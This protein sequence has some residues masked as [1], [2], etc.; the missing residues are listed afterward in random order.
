[1]LKDSSLVFYRFAPPG[2]KPVVRVVDNYSGNNTLSVIREK[3]HK[4]RILGPMKRLTEVADSV[5]DDGSQR[6]IGSPHGTSAGIAQ[7]ESRAW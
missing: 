3:N 1:M 6:E 4:V 7:G 2:M 5:L